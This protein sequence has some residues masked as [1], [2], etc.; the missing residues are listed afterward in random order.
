MNRPTLRLTSTASARTPSL[1]DRQLGQQ[2][3]RHRLL[4]KLTQASVAAQVGISYQQLRKYEDGSSRITVGRL[5]S[6]AEA[7]KVPVTQFLIDADPSACQPLSASRPSSQQADLLRHVTAMKP[8][9]QQAVFRFAKALAA[10]EPEPARHQALG[11]RSPA[12]VD[13]AAPALVRDP[14]AGLQQ[15]PSTRPAGGAIAAVL[16]VHRRTQ[17]IAHARSFGRSCRQGQ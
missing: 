6:L 10:D 3:R 1:A 14:P 12:E 11:T 16:R 13:A 5:C 8:S 2:I 7:L 17:Q 4:R 15:G 9:L